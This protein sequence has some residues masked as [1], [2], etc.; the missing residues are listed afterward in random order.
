MIIR[1]ATYSKDSEMIKYYQKGAAEITGLR[2]I[3][4]T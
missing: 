2:K 4:T 1:R 3:K